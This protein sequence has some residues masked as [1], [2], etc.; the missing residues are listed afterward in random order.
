MLKLG[1]IG[2]GKRISGVIQH[3]LRRLEPDARVVAVVDPDEAG[4]RSRLA[5]CDQSDVVFYD[6][7]EEMV[8]KAK[9][10]AVLV[11]TRCNLHAPYG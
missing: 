2:Y 4:A 11:G 8:R 3:E 5:E 10:D 9:L 1:V 7:V 6:T